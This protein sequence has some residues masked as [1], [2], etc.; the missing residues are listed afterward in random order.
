M[1][2]TFPPLAS[3]ST[4]ASGGMVP[5][6]IAPTE[7]FTVP[8]FRQALFAQMIDNEGTM[9]IDGALIGVD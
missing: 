5:T 1:P 3:Q 2:I 6:Y 8:E 9:L 7:T 4:S